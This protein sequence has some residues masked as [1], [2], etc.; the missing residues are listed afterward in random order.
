MRAARRLL[1]PR[2]ADERGGSCEPIEAPRV[3]AQLAPSV[4]PGA[5]PAAPPSGSPSQGPIVTLPSSPAGARPQQGGGEALL[6]LPKRADGTLAQDFELAPGTRLVDSYWSP[7]LCATV[8]R[9][10]GDPSASPA[11]LVSVLPEDVAVVPNH[12]YTTAADTVTPLAVDDPDPYRRLQHGLDRLGV[13]AAAG[14][15]TGAG[16]RVAVLDSA[17]EVDHR[18]LDG[19][20]VL[21]V[22]GGPPTAAATH[23]TLTTGVIAAVTGNGY[24]ISGVAPG[25]EVLAVAVCTPLGATAQDSCG[26]FD[27]LRGLDLAWGEQARVFNLSLV[28]PANPLLERATRRLDELGAVVVAAAGNEGTDAPRYPAAYPSVVGV[29]ALGPEDVVYARSNSGLSAELWAPGA[30]VL[31]TAPGGAFAFASGTSFAAAHVSGALAILIGSGAEPLAAR[32]ALFQAVP[33]TGG[34]GARRT[35]APLCEALGRLGQRCEAP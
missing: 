22:P 1:G 10:V 33:Q 35:I 11:E 30:E 14:I 27:L 24:G 19:V 7:V 3:Y 32:Q 13:E 29:G 15:S 28:G 8:A 20:R 4:E 25:A 12:V 18:D 26:L 17:P 6:A 16:A 5:Q 9:L 21:A 31:S 2:R 34:P 23:G